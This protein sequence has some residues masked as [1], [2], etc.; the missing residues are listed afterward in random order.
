[1]MDFIKDMT[2]CKRWEVS[3]TYKMCPAFSTTDAL[4]STVLLQFTSPAYE[5][6][7]DTWSNTIDAVSSAICKNIHAKPPTTQSGILSLRHWG[8]L[9]NKFWQ[10]P[11]HTQFGFL[12]PVMSLPYDFSCEGQ[13]VKINENGHIV[14]WSGSLELSS[15][16]YPCKIIGFLS[17]PVCT[18]HGG[19]IC[20]TFCLSVCLSVWTGPKI[21]LDNNSY[22]GKY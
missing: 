4:G 12:T 1:M 5:M 19:L 18:L 22:L 3:V 11:P 10:P 6:A 20:I 7:N 14:P 13:N 8:K 21:R 17:P 16:Q 9:F 2:K 15:W